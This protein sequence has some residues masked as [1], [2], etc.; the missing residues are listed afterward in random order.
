M[1]I[2][3]S[4]PKRAI[5]TTTSIHIKT[6]HHLK[7]AAGPCLKGCMRARKKARATKF[8]P[9]KETMLPT[10]LVIPV[11]SLKVGETAREKSGSTERKMSPSMEA[12]N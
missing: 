2:G 9:I 6:R 5:P 7:A 12:S 8:V 1:E 4:T 10:C 3:S 11:F